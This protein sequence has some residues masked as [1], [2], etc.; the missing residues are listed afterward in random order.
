[1]WF[2]RKQELPSCVPGGCQI[3][4]KESCHRY[5]HNRALWESF[6]TLGLS[7]RADLSASERLSGGCFAH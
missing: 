6:I 7:L 3:I 1:M 5:V 4:S 2:R